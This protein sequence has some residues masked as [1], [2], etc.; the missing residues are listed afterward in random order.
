VQITA[1]CHAIKTH[2]GVGVAAVGNTGC[3]ILVLVGYPA[4]KN[5]IILS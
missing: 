5:G 3:D 4:S 2:R 1:D